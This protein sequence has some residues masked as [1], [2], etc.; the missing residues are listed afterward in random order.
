VQAESESNTVPPSSRYL[1]TTIGWAVR[2]TWRPSG[3]HEFICW[4]LTQAKARRAAAADRA[5]W[6]QHPM[7]PTHHLVQMS[8]AQ[9]Q[10]R[11]AQQRMARQRDDER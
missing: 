8:L 1:P 10:V 3:A 6:S 4:R 11:L 7:R 9:F 5:C 2:R